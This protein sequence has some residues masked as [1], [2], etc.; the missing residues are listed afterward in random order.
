MA[1]LDLKI[2]KLIK[3]SLFLDSKKKKMLEKS[4]EVASDNEKNPY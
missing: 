4:L 2:R 1:N 3:T